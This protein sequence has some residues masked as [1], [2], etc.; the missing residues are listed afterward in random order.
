MCKK[1]I[2]VFALAALTAIVAVQ[3]ATAQSFIYNGEIAIS[4]ATLFRD[5]FK[6]PAST[7]DYIDADGDGIAG[8]FNSWPPDQLAATFVP[9]SPL[10]THWIV[11]YRGV[12]SVNG[13]SEFLAS[14]G[15]G[16][17]A[18]KIP[19][20]GR[21]NRFLYAVGG[22]INWA[23]PFAD[24][25][26]TPKTPD[27][28]DL[29][30]LDVPTDWAVQAPGGTPAW[31]LRPFTPGYGLCPITSSTGL[32]YY[33]ADLTAT[34]PGGSQVTFNKNVGNPDGF[35]IFDTPIAW[36]PSAILTNRGTGLSQIAATEL[37]YLYV[38]GRMPNGEN[39]VAATRSAG[40]GTRNG[41][42]NTLGID[43]SWG[44]G[45][46][47]G[48]ETKDK[49]YFILGPQHQATNSDSSSRLQDVAKDRR[50]AVAYSG[51]AGSDASVAQAIGGRFEIL[52]VI[53]DD[54]GGTNPV[55]PTIN[56]VLD[57]ADPN[58]GY[59]IGGPETFASLGDPFETNSA[60]PSYMSDQH[61]ADY[62]V[63]I[64]ES[65]AYFVSAPSDPEND[66][67]PGEYLATK[68]F[69][70]SGLDALPDYANFDPA[71]F[72][73]QST[74]PFNQTLQD[75]MRANVD[76][77]GGTA[78][79]DTP[80]FGSVN[81]AGL[82]P[83]RTV[84][85]PFADGITQ[86]SDGSSS[87]N[88]C[89][90][91]GSWEQIATNVKL[92]E[93]CDLSGDFN[94]DNVRDVNDADQM[95]AAYYTPRA[96]T[97]GMGYRGG[98]AG[99]PS[100][101]SGVTADT[102][103]PEV[104]GDYDGDGDFGKEDLRY[105]ADGLAID[106]GTGN[107]NRKAGAIAVDTAILA[108]APA[109]D[110]NGQP[111]TDRN[112]WFPWKSTA[113]R[114][115]IPAT[116]ACDEPTHL[117]PPDVNDPSDPFLATGATYAAGDFRGDVAGGSP[118]AGAQPLGWDGQVDAVDIDYVC[119]NI[120]NW[121]DLDQ[122][123]LIDLSADMNGDLIIDMND[124]TEIVTAILKTQLGDVDLDGDVDDDDKAIVIA[125]QGQQGGWAMGDM[126]CDRMID[127]DDLAVF[128]SVTPVSP[129]SWQSVR[130]HG[131]AGELTIDL[132]ASDGT[133][134]VE[135]RN[136]GLQKIVVV[137]DGDLTAAGYAAG[138]VTITGPDLSVSGEAIITTS[139]PNDTLVLT[140][141]GSVDKTCYTIDVGGVCVLT[142]GADATCSI[143]ALAGDSNGDKRVS[144]TDM[145]LV[146]SRVG[147][148][149]AANVRAD[150]NCDGGIST[151]DMAL[152]RSKVAAPTHVC[153]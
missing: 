122:A 66:G 70:S 78:H 94:Q 11:Q 137:F 76:L 117:L 144:T 46:N 31:N 140:L 114:V 45:D 61:V 72:V 37:Q 133:A 4:G 91:V 102:I 36:V 67:M 130:T 146:R 148:S 40:S 89:Y 125:N 83:T 29:A 52:D 145:A 23:G 84:N 16:T 26:G 115:L 127:Q 1:R 92:P 55:R 58:T 113:K 60:V 21:F 32:S 134:T 71:N 98:Q 30:V 142:A 131:A 33:L 34:C 109:N 128:S 152:A 143:L 13:L 8:K 62:L 6:F 86:Y 120:G 121:G 50:L 10:T 106:V 51:L 103:I 9:G 14:Q 57:N 22:G 85:P 116:T 90:W 95:V 107:L 12:G 138:G 73:L 96:W 110:E 147:Q 101:P 41:V 111:V 132:S 135:C 88:Y 69:L 141:S 68:F 17:V 79:V 20:P 5:F 123:A 124:H 28:I 64:V 54:R 87:G 65:V 93:S 150:V 19:D 25:S 35:T 24:V 149:V 126:N 75:Y 108:H 53:F 44:R 48:N 112:H 118:V 27:Q 18:T 39:L 3:S 97:V 2:A 59:Q 104:I 77:I 81:K 49:Q 42:M 15:C 136:N 100:T 129:I 74:P 153:P 105:F 38:T 119:Q 99:G 151:T 80:A 63:N 139:V 43:P 7:N 56:S 82:A 47:M